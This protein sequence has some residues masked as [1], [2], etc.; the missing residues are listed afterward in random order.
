MAGISLLQFEPP[1][2]FTAGKLAGEILDLCRRNGH[3]GLSRVR[4]AV[5][6]GDGGLYDPLNHFPNYIIQAWP[7]EPGSAGLNQN[8]LEIGIFPDGRKSCDPYSNLKSNNYLLYVLA[9]LYAGRRQL[10]D[11]LVLNS[12][13]RI[14]DSTISNLFWCRKG[15]IF[16]PPLSEGCVAGVMRRWLL[17]VLP[18]AGYVL[19]E[20]TTTAEDLAGAEEVFLTNAMRPVRWVKAFRGTNYGAQLATSIFHEVIRKMP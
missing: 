6:R 14:A 19:R 1:V 12:H 17:E 2:S 20:K 7:L 5:F 9:A 4:L 8:G 16:T 3:K 11:C 13:G 15:E 18:A 10:N